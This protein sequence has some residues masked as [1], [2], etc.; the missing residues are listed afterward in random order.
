M[1]KLIAL[2]IDVTKFDKSKLVKGKKG[3]YANITISVNDEEDQF[4]NDVSV[5]E[6]QSK[7]ERDAKENRNFLG[8]G[9]TIWSSEE[10]APK[11]P[12]GKKV[13]VEEED[14]LLPF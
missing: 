11:K 1:A 8:N 7:E 3:T 10:S 5:W 13:A 9:K 12:S 2:S 4:G 6:S 14:D